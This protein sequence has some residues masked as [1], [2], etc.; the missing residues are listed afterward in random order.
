MIV[1]SVGVG[2]WGARFELCRV[3]THAAGL[4]RGS[5]RTLKPAPDLDH[6][7]GALCGGDFFWVVGRVRDVVRLGP[8]FGALWG[9]WGLRDAHTSPVPFPALSNR[10]ILAAL[11]YS[12]FESPF[13]SVW[14]SCRK[15]RDYERSSDY[16]SVYSRGLTECVG[17]S[18]TERLT[19]VVV[20]VEPWQ[21]DNVPPW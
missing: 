8:T 7:M 9:F 5:F 13:G 16:R 20:V 15:L 3:Y 12:L 2:G 19:T 1:S 11:V 21:L 10:R 14:H 4:D 6:E 17:K 18:A